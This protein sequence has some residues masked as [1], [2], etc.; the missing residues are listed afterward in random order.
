MEDTIIISDI[1]KI[2][3][4]KY[5]KEPAKDLPE[6]YQRYPNGGEYGCFLWVND[7]RAMFYWDIDLSRWKI[8]TPTNAKHFVE[9]P[10]LM[11][12]GDSLIY[13]INT[14]GF[15]VFSLR[16]ALSLSI[17]K[18]YLTKAVMEAD[19]NPID[20]NTLLPLEYGQVVAV[21]DD[22]LRVNNGVYRYVSPGWDLV[23]SYGESLNYLKENFSS[24][25]IARIYDSLAIMQA[26]LTPTNV[27]TGDPLLK[28]ELVSISNPL[29]EADPDNGKVYA[30]N[31]TGWSYMGTLNN[32]IAMEYTNN[33]FDTI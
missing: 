31:T 25:Q 8:L 17:R 3:V 22:P 27:N 2:P 13:D 9:N 29:D 5:L 12:D 18:T 16:K 10:E 26:D 28:G 7:E 6:V 30:W 19:T 4:L 23:F 1:T 20:E 15:K 32:L 14:G 21:S 24:L 11:E 33:Y